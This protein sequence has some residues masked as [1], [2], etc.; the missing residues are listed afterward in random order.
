MMCDGSF[1]LVSTLGRDVGE[2]DSRRCEVMC[3]VCK[4]VQRGVRGHQ[5]DRPRVR[6]NFHNIEPADQLKD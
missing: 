5:G 4:T 6:V 2:E 1:E 3:P